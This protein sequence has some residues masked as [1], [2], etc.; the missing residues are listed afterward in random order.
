MKAYI[1]CSNKVLYPFGD[2]TQECLIGNEKLSVLQRKILSSLLNVFPEYISDQ[3]EIDCEEEYITFGDNVYFTQELLKEFIRKSRE[4]ECRTTCSLKT[5]ITTKRT[6]VDTQEVEKY[7]NYVGYNL[8][9]TPKVGLRDKNSQNVVI[10]PDV[11]Q[12][13]RTAY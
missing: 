4:M 12:L 13:A 11:I 1:L 10:N 2:N 7:P 6:V 5:G 9:Y 3:S 8:H